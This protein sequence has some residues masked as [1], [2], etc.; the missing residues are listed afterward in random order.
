MFTKEFRIVETIE[1]QIK[2]QFPVVKR[3]GHFNRD[4]FKSGDRVHLQHPLTRK[5]DILGNISKELEASDGSIQSYE[6]DTHMG[7]NLIC[8]GSNIRHSESAE[9]DRAESS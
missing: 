9:S 5:L 8:N 4:V 2:H 3:R 6:V 7:Q 1:K